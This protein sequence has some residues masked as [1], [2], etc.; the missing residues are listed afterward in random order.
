M[1]TASVLHSIFSCH[2]AQ[3]SSEL[4]Q[5]LPKSSNQKTMETNI[6]QHTRAAEVAGVQSILPPVAA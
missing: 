5:M 6:A 4:H 3:A 1:L 2:T